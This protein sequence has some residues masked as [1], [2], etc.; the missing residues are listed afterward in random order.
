M[1]SQVKQLC[2][3]ILGC[4]SLPEPEADPAEFLK[5]LRQQQATVP[6]VF[7]PTKRVLLPWFDLKGLSSLL[8]LGSSCVLI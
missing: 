4:E 1:P 2:E 6:P 7:H 8:N 3:L 5:A